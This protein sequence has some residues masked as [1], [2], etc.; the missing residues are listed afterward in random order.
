LRA[1]ER[2]IALGILAHLLT[3][4]CVPALHTL[5]H[6]ADHRHLPG[7]G[8]ETV[9]LHDHGG[10]HDGAPDPSH[11]SGSAE[12]FDAAPLAPTPFLLPPPAVAADQLR[13]LP[14][15][16]VFLGRIEDDTRAPR[17]PPRAS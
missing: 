15:R 3:F 1:D 11:G 6:R 9:P 12:H 16:S 2:I 7:G 14:A 13:P 10:S 4:L 8:I 5:G 17:G